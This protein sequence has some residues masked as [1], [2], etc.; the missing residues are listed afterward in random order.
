MAYAWRQITSTGAHALRASW[1]WL[2]HLSTSEWLMLLAATTVVGFV[3]MR[4]LSSR[5]GR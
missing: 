3:C 5:I 1:S 2:D 4:G